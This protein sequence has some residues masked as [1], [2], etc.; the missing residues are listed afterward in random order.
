MAGA[1]VEMLARRDSAAV[2]GALGLLIFLSWLAVL[3]GAGTGMDPAA[4]SG[5]LMPFALPASS[6][7]WTPLYWLIAF[8]MWAVMMVAMMLPSAS[9]MILLYARVVRQAES[10]GKARHASA[11]I[12]AFA[13]GYLALWSLFSA[14][15]VAAQF[16]LERAGA[17]SAMMSSRSA[18][19]SGALLIAAG[20]YQ[21]TPLKSACLNHCRGPAAFIAAHWRP[22]VLG[23]FRMGLAHGAYC[24][25]CC[26]A[27][28]LLLFAGGIMNLVW[29]AGLAL[30][31]GFEKLAP[32]GAVAAKAIAV[33]LIGAGAALIVLT[34]I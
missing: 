14:F 4:M 33:V 8:C 21:L 26:A 27:L 24:V 7:A 13:S 16:G 15:A 25:G 22:G 32:F 34:G 23:A 9:P 12:A 29:I 18:L 31:V 2:V 5:L 11:S 6:S 10:A 30:I 20:L 28:M 17:L 3:A 1:W 19:L